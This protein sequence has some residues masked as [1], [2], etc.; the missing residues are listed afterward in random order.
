MDKLSNAIILDDR[1]NLLLNSETEGDR[2]YGMLKTIH[3]YF[4][5]NSIPFT[6]IEGINGPVSELIAKLKSVS[7]PD[8][9]VLDLDLNS[10]GII[11]DYDKELIKVILVTLKSTFQDFILLIYSS[12]DE[13]WYEIKSEIIEEE[14][15][16]QKVLNDDNV[17]VFKKTITLTPQQEQILTLK[18]RTLSVKYFDRQLK[19]INDYFKRTWN[20]EVLVILFFLL[21]LSTIIHFSFRSSNTIYIM[22]IVSMI[23][24]AL[25]Y[26]VES[27]SKKK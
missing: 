24:T 22:V 27:K 12:Q 2:E 14:L 17:F 1:I 4:L 13:S 6:V 23:I 26:I 18:L 11:D 16:L 9:V 10:N 19:F 21:C 20:K 5:H 25:V 7:K 3:N 8:L 15:D